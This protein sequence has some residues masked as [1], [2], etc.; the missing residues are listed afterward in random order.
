LPTICID[1]VHATLNENY[2]ETRN[3]IFNGC[4][5]VSGYDFIY[6]SNKMSLVPNPTAG[7][8]RIFS[9]SL[10]GSEVEVM[11]CDALGRMVFRRMDVIEAGYTGP[12]DVSAFAPGM[13]LVRMKAGNLELTERLI[14]L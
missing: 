13:Y 1:A 12:I 14:R 7:N 3:A 10:N 4:Q 9:E 2:E 6:R 5:L 11:V 8:F